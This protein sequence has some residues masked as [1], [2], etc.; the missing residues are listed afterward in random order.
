MKEIESKNTNK[1]A[2]KSDKRIATKSKIS[3]TK[4]MKSKPK[5]TDK[6]I[7]KKDTTEA[8]KK[9]KKKKISKTFE[10]RQRSNT[11]DTFLN[12]M[13]S[14]MSTVEH[15]EMESI[16]SNDKFEDKLQD[17]KDFKMRTLPTHGSNVTQEEDEWHYD[18]AL[19]ISDDEQIDASNDTNLLIAPVF[20]LKVC[21]CEY[22][23]G[24]WMYF[25]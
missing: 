5:Y 25:D 9:K 23:W 21:V 1:Q 6:R 22:L 16:L 15:K 4:K 12:E 20:K 10:N 17:N 2:N 3:K 14:D 13:V 24:K 11:D 7:Q 8:Q 19:K 18:D